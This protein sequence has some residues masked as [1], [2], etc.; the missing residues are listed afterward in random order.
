MYTLLL[1]DRIASGLME[2]HLDYHQGWVP[3]KQLV[4]PLAM[5]QFLNLSPTS[6]FW[7]LCGRTVDPDS[8]DFRHVPGGI[9]IAMAL[10]M[11]LHTQTFSGSELA[12]S[13]LQPGRAQDP[14]AS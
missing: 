11:Y 3:G 2:Q 14:T 13:F 6:H 10:F 9:P 8:L 4:E 7:I 5:A 12:R 1:G